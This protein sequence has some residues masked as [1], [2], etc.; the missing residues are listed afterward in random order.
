[1]L[2]AEK[3]KMQLQRW[4]LQRAAAAPHAAAC[5]ADVPVAGLAPRPPTAL[6]APMPAPKCIT[7]E[8][9][10]AWL[11]ECGMLTGELDSGAVVRSWLDTLRLL[12]TPQGYIYVHT[13]VCIYIYIYIYI[14]IRCGLMQKS[15][16]EE[17]KR[18]TER[19]VGKRRAG[20]R[21]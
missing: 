14:Y 15:R 7:M 18:E 2:T 16:E 20:A 6:P 1:M 8:A 17:R 13:Y 21:R 19:E 11:E 3:S 5:A 10:I 12:H 9:F 4:F